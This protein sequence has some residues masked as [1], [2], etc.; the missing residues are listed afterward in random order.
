MQQDDSLAC[1]VGTL[2]KVTYCGWD[3]CIEGK[4]YESFF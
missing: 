4:L 1:S 2:D 3:Y